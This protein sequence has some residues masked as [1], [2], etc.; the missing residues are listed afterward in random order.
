MAAIGEVN[1]WRLNSFLKIWM[2]Q[3]NV[4]GITSYCRNYSCT[5]GRRGLF[6][7]LF[8]LFL[9]TR[10]G[11]LG[12]GESVRVWSFQSLAH[13]EIPVEH[14]IKVN[15]LILNVLLAYLRLI[16][17]HVVQLASGRIGPFLDLSLSDRSLAEIFEWEVE[18]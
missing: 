7:Y 8:V 3:L 13:F 1:G 12:S 5:A 17:L 15:P 6:L 14:L 4:F 2:V 9:D 10:F 11:I 18:I 16:Y